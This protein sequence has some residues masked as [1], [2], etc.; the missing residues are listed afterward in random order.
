MPKLWFHLIFCFNVRNHCI[1]L[2]FLTNIGQSTQNWLIIFGMDFTPTSTPMLCWHG[3][4]TESDKFAQLRVYHKYL[5]KFY[6]K[7]LKSYTK[8][9]IIFWITLSALLFN[10]PFYVTFFHFTLITKIM[11]FSFWKLIYLSVCGLILMTWLV[12]THLVYRFF[13][14]EVRRKSKYVEL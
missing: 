13:L 2:E 5:L 11:S 8:L 12:W 9:L 6:T 14:L 7:L 4:G 3:C 1:C 10:T